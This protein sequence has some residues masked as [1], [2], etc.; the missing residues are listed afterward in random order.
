MLIA[1]SGCYLIDVKYPTFSPTEGKS[2]DTVIGRYQI[3]PM[4]VI[5]EEEF[6][7]A[8]ASEQSIADLTR[9]FLGRLIEHRKGAVLRFHP[10]D[11]RVPQGCLLLAEEPNESGPPVSEDM[12][13]FRAV[14]FVDS[15]DGGLLLQMPYANPKEKPATVVEIVDAEKEEEEPTEEE[16]YDNIQNMFW[17]AEREWDPKLVSYN[18]LKLTPVKDGFEVRVLDYEFVSTATKEDKLAGHDPDQEANIGHVYVVDAKPKAW[19]KFVAENFDGKLFDPTPVMKLK[20]LN[21]AAPQ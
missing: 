16:E 3:E 11:D 15:F 2:S 13:K 18:V 14:V 12:A 20:K 21:A 9:Y 5:S 17:S 10:A 7:Q 4:N 6:R 19:R 8:K 1:C